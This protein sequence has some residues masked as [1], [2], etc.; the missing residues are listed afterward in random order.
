MSFWKDKSLWVY[1]IGLTVMFMIVAVLAFMHTHDFQ[2]SLVFFAKIFILMQPI[3][4]GAHFVDR[5]YRR[6]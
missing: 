6:R 3:I 1:E 5:K 4:L 2:N